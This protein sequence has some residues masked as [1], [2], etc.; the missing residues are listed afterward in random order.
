MSGQRQFI[1]LNRRPR[2]PEKWQ[3]ISCG[4]LNFAVNV[5]TA[6]ILVAVV[7]LILWCLK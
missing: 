3:D 6:V 5:F 1:Y 2:P 4:P 7:G